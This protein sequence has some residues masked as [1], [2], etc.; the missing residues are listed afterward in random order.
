MVLYAV[1]FPFGDAKMK[2]N[3]IFEIILFTVLLSIGILFII[4]KSK[5]YVEPT[6]WAYKTGLRADISIFR[7]FPVVLFAGAFLCLFKLI[8]SVISMNK[9]L[10]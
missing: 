9:R 8:L 1:I 7:L 2:K 4:L 6:D 5:F 10:F 3:I